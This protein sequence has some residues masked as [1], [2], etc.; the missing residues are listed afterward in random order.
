MMRFLTVAALLATAVAAPASA[1]TLIAGFN[2]AGTAV[3]SVTRQNTSLKVDV[4]VRRFNALPNSLTNFSQT[5]AATA[6]MTISRTAGGL[7]ITGGGSGTQMDTNSAGTMAN[8]LR[9]SFLLTGS[10]A[11]RLTGLTL[12]SVDND[13]TV[14]VYGIRADNTFANLGFGTGTSTTL[15]PGGL[16]AGTIKGGA[17]GTLLNLVNTAPNGG[18]SSFDFVNDVR[19]TRYLITTRARGDVN[20]LGTA[21]QGFALSGLVATVPEPATWGLLLVG[22][23]LVGVAARRRSVAVTA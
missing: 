14:Q 2:G 7:G 8:P 9:E 23:G 5:T 6:A 22:F 11:F 1:V 10:N 16:A 17:G 21:G 12:T 18:T 20:Y 13:D 3:T 15:V 4:T 19:F